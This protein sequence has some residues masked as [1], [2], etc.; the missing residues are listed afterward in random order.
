[1]SKHSNCENR[2][3]LR[4][5]A[6]ASE[7]QPKL[8]RETFK[9]FPLWPQSFSPPSN[10]RPF[11]LQPSKMT[12]QDSNT[13]YIFS[14]PHLGWGLPLCF[15]HLS[16][17]YTPTPSLALGISASALWPPS[18]L[19][20]GNGFLLSYLFF[21]FSLSHL[22]QPHAEWSFLLDWKFPEKRNSILAYLVQ[23][24]SLGGLGWTGLQTG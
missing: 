23:S 14:F 18:A 9:V 15:R 20:W 5:L 24:L 11:R 16:Q 21:G 6:A 4:W 8:L 2:Q 10:Q 3:K 13:S 22:A 17:F 1:M 7:I 12:H 19:Q